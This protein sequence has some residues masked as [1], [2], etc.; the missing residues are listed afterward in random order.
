[1]TVRANKPEFNIREKL[2]ELESV[3]YNK[4]PTGS[5][6]QVSHYQ[7]PGEVSLN[8]SSFATA[9]THQFKPKKASSKLVHH[10]WTKSVLNNTSSPA[11][12]DYKVM[13]GPSLTNIGYHET[14]IQASWQNYFNQSDYTADFYPPL[15]FVFVHQPFTTELYNYTLQG[16]IYGGSN[17]TWQI[18]KINMSS[19]DLISTHNRGCW[20][21][22][23]VVE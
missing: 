19:G 8:T 7:I 10:F 6:I 15:D 4:M 11:G 18:G 16:R 3:S 9:Y 13:G 5:V 21:I 22:Y 2:K 14:V 1:M 20:V 23:E 12:Q 17:A